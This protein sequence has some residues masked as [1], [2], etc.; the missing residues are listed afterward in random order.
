MCDLQA[1]IGCDNRSLVVDWCN[2]DVNG[3]WQAVFLYFCLVGHNGEVVPRCLTAIMDIRDVLLLYLEP[4][5]GHK[6][7][8]SNYFCLILMDIFSQRKVFYHACIDLSLIKAD[9]STLMHACLIQM[10]TI[11]KSSVTSKEVHIELKNMLDVDIN[12]VFRCV[13]CSQSN[14]SVSES[15]DRHP[16]NPAVL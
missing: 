5:V 15:I 10:L 8:V 7:N 9:H 4:N 3:A 6:D 1:L 16:W 13:F 2:N 12:V 11:S 14:L